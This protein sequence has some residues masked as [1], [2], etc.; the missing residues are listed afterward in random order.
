M[1]KS[2]IWITVVLLALLVGCADLPDGPV[3]PSREVVLPTVDPRLAQESSPSAET[4]SD[5]EDPLTPGGL[6]PSE[7]D[8]NGETLPAPSETKSARPE[9]TEP[10]VSFEWTPFLPDETDP[11][12]PTDP[13][14]PIFTI[15]PNPSRPGILDP[16]PAQPKPTEPEPTQPKPTEPKPTEP[17]PTQPKPTEPEPTQPKPTEPPA[18][19]PTTGVSV[20]PDNGTSP[21]TDGLQILYVGPYSGPYY[22]DG[23]SDEV[24]SVASMLLE[25]VSRQH[26]QYAELSLDIG[27]KTALFQ[28]SDLPPGERVLVLEAN[29]LQIWPEQDATLLKDRTVQTFTAPADD[30]FLDFRSDGGNLTVTNNGK[31]T[32]NSVDVS[33]KLRQDKETLLGGVSFH[34]RFGKLAAGESRTVAAGHYDPDKC[35]IVYVKVN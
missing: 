8:L 18:T 23:S 16:S 17:E 13:A 22:E 27:G 11:A 15:E 35:T 33:Y 25:N 29:R 9:E 10:S 32:V 21:V 12:A 28:I 2:L 30:S 1:R 26:L 7:P 20:D 6:K 14:N 4:G 19:S 5:A 34:V 24:S 3:L 31:R